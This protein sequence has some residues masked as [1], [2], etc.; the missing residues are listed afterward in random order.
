MEKTKHKGVEKRKFQRLE[1][2]LNVTLKV[3][4]DEDMPGKGKPVKLKSRDISLE[5]ISLETRDIVVDGINVL[6]GSPGARENM[7]DME[8]ELVAGENPVKAVGEVCWY[9]VIRDSE[10]FMYQ[11]GVV[12]IKIE[13]TAKEQ[14]KNFLKSSVKNP[15]FFKKLFG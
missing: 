10:E 9:D 4:T 8:I 5:G 11:I 6:S 1:I 7:L 12:F 14:L 13:G 2:P 3:I 15:G